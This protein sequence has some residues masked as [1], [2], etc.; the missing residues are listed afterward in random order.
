MKRFLYIFIAIIML[1]LGL[2]FA[3]KNAQTASISYYFGIHWEGPMSLLLLTALTFGVLLGFLAS[4]AMVIRMQ[5]QL[6]R[7]RREVR[8]IEQEVMNLR[9]LPI[10]DVI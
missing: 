6:V 4:I 2:S 1:F 8:N 7:A 3:Y 9:S 10:K 5:R